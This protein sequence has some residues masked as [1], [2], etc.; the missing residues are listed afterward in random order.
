MA[1]CRAA[2]IVYFDFKVVRQSSEA[3]LANVYGK[4]FAGGYKAV[5]K[6]IGDAMPHWLNICTASP[7]LHAFVIVPQ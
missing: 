1:L 7:P 3:F 4:Q 6:R 5:A 2:A